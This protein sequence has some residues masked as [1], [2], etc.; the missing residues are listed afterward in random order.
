MKIYLT[1]LLWQMRGGCSG[2]RMLFVLHLPVVSLFVINEEKHRQ[3]MS[4]LFL[5]GL[6]H[7]FNVARGDFGH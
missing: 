5:W 6:A 1:V 2:R 3:L 4:H 7:P